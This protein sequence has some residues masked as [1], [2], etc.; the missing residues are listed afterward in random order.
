MRKTFLCAHCG[1]PVP[2]G[3]LACPQCGADE[4]T[5]W[6]PAAGELLPGD[7]D[8]LLGVGGLRADLPPKRRSVSLLTGAVLALL[9]AALLLPLTGPW[10]ALGGLALGLGAAWLLRRPQARPARQGDA[11]SRMYRE[12]LERTKGDAAMVE[13][14]LESEARRAP[15]AS[16]RELLAAALYRLGR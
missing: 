14:L 5:G 7:D 8:E 6:S 16:R 4:N 3:A 2:A 13:R 12:L 1:A 9:V 15:G 11:E 10:I